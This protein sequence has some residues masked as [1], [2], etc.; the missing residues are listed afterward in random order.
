LIFTPAFSALI[1]S[2]FSSCS[3]HHRNLPSSLHDALPIY[4]PERNSLTCSRGSVPSTCEARTSKSCGN[5]AGALRPRSRPAA[6]AS[7]EFRSEEHTSELQSRFDLVC[8]L[9]L[10]KKKDY[11][12]WYEQQEL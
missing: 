8:R 10:E 9:L 2:F 11:H 12:N 4:K 6:K 1:L 5:M 3:Y 7:A